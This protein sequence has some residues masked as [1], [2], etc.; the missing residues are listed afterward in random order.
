M[1]TVYEVAVSIFG[2]TNQTYALLS[3]YTVQT[4]CKRLSCSL[5]RLSFKHKDTS[6]LTQGSGV[7]LFPLLVASDCLRRTTSVSSMPGI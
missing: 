4:A 1:Y 6:G 2:V 3:L 7:F 5:Y